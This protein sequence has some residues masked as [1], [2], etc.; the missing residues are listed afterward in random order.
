MT[1]DCVIIGAGQAGLCL[2][3]FLTKKNITVLILERDERIGDVWRRRPD[4]MRLF[5]P[6][7][8]NQLPGLIMA[9]DQK[10]YPL[11]LI[12]AQWFLLLKINNLNQVYFYYQ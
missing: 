10:G 7:A 4:S 2:A 6:R 9:G 12:F 1:Y 5:T 11:S 8:M 3:S